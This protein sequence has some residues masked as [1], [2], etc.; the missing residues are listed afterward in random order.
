[1][2]QW[3]LR[4]KASKNKEADQAV[5]SKIREIYDVNEEFKIINL[6]VLDKNNKEY[7]AYRL[8]VE[9][10]KAQADSFHIEIDKTI[11]IKEIKA[12]KIV[13]S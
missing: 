4:T 11:I 3:L 8:K 5:I 10:F 2:E 12:I 1:M 9:G 13:L 6:G 7:V